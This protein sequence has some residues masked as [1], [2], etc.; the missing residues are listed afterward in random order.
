[1]SI[2]YLID[3]IKFQK[4]VFPAKIKS[5]IY[6]YIMKSPCIEMR[7]KYNP[8][9]GF[10]FTWL[11]GINELV[12]KTA[13]KEEKVTKKVSLL[14]KQI[15]VEPIDEE[16]PYRQGDTLEIEDIFTICLDSITFYKKGKYY[17]EVIENGRITYEST[18]ELESN[19]KLEEG[20]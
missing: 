16:K 2:N 12:D 15:T 4:I 8:K 13:L 5:D 11:C 18:I 20:K 17:V 10:S 3:N 19:K 14:S 1:M 9:K 6:P 7:V